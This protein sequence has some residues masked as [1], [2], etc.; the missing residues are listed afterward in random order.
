MWFTCYTVSTYSLD[1]CW[2]EGQ[3]QDIKY[4]WSNGA[5]A[6]HCPWSNR[7]VKDFQEIGWSMDCNE[8]P[9]KIFLLW[10]Q[11]TCL[12]SKWKPR[13]WYYIC[14]FPCTM[15]FQ[16]LGFILL[17]VWSICSKEVIFFEFSL[18]Y[19]K[20][21]NFSILQEMIKYRTWFLLFFLLL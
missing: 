11:S 15:T 5:W 12:W 13:W 17:I 9:Y 14:L 16:N 7:H 19:N 10:F 4:Y 1:E 18:T 6:F 8:E 3:S 21:P 2:E 20:T